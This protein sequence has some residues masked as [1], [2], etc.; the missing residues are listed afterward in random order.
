MKARILST[1]GLWAIVTVALALGKAWAGLAL[2]VLL[3]GAAQWE[4]YTLLEKLGATPRKALGVALGAMLPICVFIKAT[5][6]FSDTPVNQVALRTEMYA[7]IAIALVVTA[8]FYVQLA[9][10]TGLLGVFRKTPT[11]AGLLGFP[12]MMSL[13]AWPA[14]IEW[15]KN[16]DLSGMYWAVWCVAATKFT[17]VG[18]LLSGKFF[19]RN[20]LWPAVS[21]GKTREGCLGGILMSC[22]VA[23]GLAYAFDGHWSLNL[24]PAKAAL[25]ALPLAVNSIPSD[26]VESVFKRLSGVKD[27]GRTIPGIGGAYDLADSLLLNAPVSLALYLFVTA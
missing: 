27:S 13:Y 20:K 16:Q 15:G 22:G 11:A 6:V 25:V 5:G 14:A 10:H 24:P 23:A 21:P 26:L 18:G 9:L 4:F 3:G 1:L 7:F 8:V 2:I 12:L 17:D 19:G